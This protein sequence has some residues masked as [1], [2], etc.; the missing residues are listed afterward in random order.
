MFRKRSASV[1]INIK[2]AFFIPPGLRAITS[3]WTISKA[4]F[5]FNLP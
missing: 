3:P 5:N 1:S 2:H 4:L